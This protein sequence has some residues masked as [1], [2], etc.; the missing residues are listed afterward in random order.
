MIMSCT[1]FEQ[2][3][4]VIRAQMVAELDRELV[5]ELG[6]HRLLL[7]FD[8]PRNFSSKSFSWKDFERA[9]ESQLIRELGGH[10]LLLCFDDP[11]NFLLKEFERKHS[12]VSSYSP[13]RDSALVCPALR[14]IFSDT[15]HARVLYN[16]PA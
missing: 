12:A 1:T 15:S 13:Q 11:R 9:L 10:R 7:C 8:V 6:G 2:Q 14:R 3:H 5:P 4:I 16:T